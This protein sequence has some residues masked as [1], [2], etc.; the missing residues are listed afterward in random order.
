MNKNK[1]DERLKLE[2]H[3]IRTLRTVYPYGLNERV[4]DKITGN[5]QNIG[6]LFPPLQRNGPAFRPERGNRNI[7][8]ENVAVENFFKLV[9]EYIIYDKKNSFF[10]IRILLNKIRKKTLKEICTNVLLKKEGLHQVD[11]FYQWYDL[12]CDIIDTKL[13]KPIIK[14]PKNAP[15]F[16]CSKFY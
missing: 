5:H 11:I 10:K 6:S 3:A 9:K 7:K 14:D 13:Y 4:K 12:I 1:L 8:K 15:K 2:D 16:V